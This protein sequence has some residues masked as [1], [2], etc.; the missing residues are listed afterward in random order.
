M[1]LTNTIFIQPI[2]DTYMS[3]TYVNNNN[4][5]CLYGITNTKLFLKE[6]CK[7]ISKSTMC[8]TLIKPRFF[9]MSVVLYRF[10]IPEKFWICNPSNIF[11]RTLH[12]FTRSVNRACYMLFV[13]Y[14]LGYFSYF[15][16]LFCT[17]ICAGKPSQL[18][19]SLV[20]I[21]EH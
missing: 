6:E 7:D 1:N 18:L 5:M 11:K 16:L 17:Y 4:T 12:Y 14:F 19:A 8:D 3:A 13:F 2:L 15:Y 9:V 21:K 20:G 10:L